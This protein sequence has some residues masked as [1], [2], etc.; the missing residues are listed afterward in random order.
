MVL[1][2][3]TDERIQ[4][5]AVVPLE[6]GAVVAVTQGQQK[7]MYQIRWAEI[8]RSVVAGGAQDIVRAHASQLGTID[9]ATGRIVRFRWVPTPGSIVEQP[10]EY[11]EGMP[12]GQ[13]F[14]LGSLVGTNVPIYLDIATA[15]EGHLAILGMTRMG[16]TTFASRLAREL[17]KTHRV[18]VIDITGEWVSK[19]A[20]AAYSGP[21][22][23]DSIG[24][25][26]L[27]PKAGSNPADAAQIYFSEVANKAFAEYKAG[28][29]IP[30]VLLFDE[31]HQFVP[32]P[33][34][35]GFN[36]PGR[37]STQKF[38]QLMMQVR[39]YGISVVLVSQRTAVVAKT[40]LSQCETLVAFK[41]VDQTGLEFLD[42]VL[43]SESKRALPALKHAEALVFGPAVSSEA[44][45]AVAMLA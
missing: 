45:V 44:T 18:T 41:S 3:S 5:I 23:D 13:A 16:K 2:G 33:A 32:E 35:L 31:A 11:G 42:A 4:F 29:V 39:K 6:I 21:A 15:C 8:E 12:N 14:L 17:A 34:L 36:T 27:E 20:F 40:A 43:G 30:R 7:V 19:R 9:A 37:E 10:L 1:D 22:D 24:V 28:K 25:S 26:V 38:G